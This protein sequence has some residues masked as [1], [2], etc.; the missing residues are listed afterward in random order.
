MAKVFY[1]NLVELDKIEKALK[2][3]IDYKEEREEFEKIID[4]IMHHKVLGCVF[5]ELPMEHHHEFVVKLHKAPH[6]EGL[7]DYLS[8]KIQ[9]DM[10]EFIRMEILSLVQEII[11]DIKSQKKNK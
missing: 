9:K 2:K 11:N 5:H 7:L 1:D 8:E 3:V 10:R 6:D 4:E